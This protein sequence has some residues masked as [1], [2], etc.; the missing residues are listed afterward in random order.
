M[1]LVFAELHGYIEL[2]RFEG[3]PMDE[4]ISVPAGEVQRHFALWQDRALTRPV[5]VTSRGRPRV[6]ML[7][8]EEYERL[9]RRDRQ[10]LRVEDL[11][12][13]LV[14]AIAASEPPEE[15]RRF[16]GEVG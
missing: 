4:P 13:E 2:G 5:A 1:K 16:D 9:R 12:D 3:I 15:A 14:D 6:V 7:S 11:P 8:V 10:A